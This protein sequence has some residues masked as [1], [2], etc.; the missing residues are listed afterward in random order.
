MSPVELEVPAEEETKMGIVVGF[1]G[2]VLCAYPV[3]LEVPVE[4]GK[5][6][7]HYLPKM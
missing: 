4:E 6:M 7:G 3:E 5:K 1:V 2:C